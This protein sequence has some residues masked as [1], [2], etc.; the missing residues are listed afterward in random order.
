[1]AHGVVAPPAC[2]RIL[3][4]PRRRAAAGGAQELAA[5]NKDDPQTKNEQPARVFSAVEIKQT[6]GGVSIKTALRTAVS[7]SCHNYFK[8]S[9]T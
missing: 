2:R 4:S 9:P 6:K 1:V 5:V 8:I 7:C 3:L